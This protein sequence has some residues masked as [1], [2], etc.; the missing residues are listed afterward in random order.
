MRKFSKKL[1]IFALIIGALLPIFGGNRLT[2]ADGDEVTRETV[3]TCPSQ[4]KSDRNFLGL[5]PWYAGL[6]SKDG[7]T[8][9]LP[10]C[11]DDECSAL[12]TSIWQIA[13]NVLQD[14]AVIAAYLTIG[15]AI[16]GGYQYLLSRGSVD[17]A[18]NGKKTIITAFIGLAITM[19]ASVIFGVIKYAIAKDALDT[20]IVTSGGLSIE[21]PNVEPNLAFT[22]TMTWVIGTAGLVAAIFLVYGGAVYVSSRGEATKIETAKKT[23]IYSV[24]GLIIV[25]VAQAGIALV[26]SGI[27]DSRDKAIE[28]AK[29]K[30]KTGLIITIEKEK[31]A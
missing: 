6:C 1:I 15:F 10:K 29:A 20:A 17:K 24:I 27:K 8:V 2:Y 23:I 3:T 19:L 31:E 5:L 30:A 13:F 4:I 11:T 28:D 7:E 22:N 12:K 21:I 16:Y 18:L 25:G 9:E 14:L 26:S